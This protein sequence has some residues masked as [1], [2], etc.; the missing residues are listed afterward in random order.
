MPL[1]AG[2]LVTQRYR[3][4][5]L[6]GEG[7]FGA[8]YLAEDTRLG[9]KCV[10]LKES[11]DNSAEART[12]F[13]LEAQLLAKL[14]H[15]CLP[16]VTDNFI[17]TDGRQFLVMD[18][19][20]GDDLHERVIKAGRPLTEREAVTIMVQVCEA[21]AYLHTRKPQPVIHR[22]IKPPNI[23]ITRDG[24]AVLVD[25]GIAKVYNP[26]KGTAKVAKAFSPH[27]SPP[28]QYIGKTDTRSD[29]YALGATL[30]CLVCAILPP[31]AMERLTEGALVRS[32][33]KLNPSLSPALE[34]IILQ[35]L[36]LNPDKRFLNANH[37]AA[38]LRMLQAGTPQA[39]AGGNVTCP[40]CGWQNRSGSRF[41]AKDGTPLQPVKPAPGPSPAG[42]QAVLAAISPEMQFE[43]A[44]AFARN[45][46]WPQAIS[47]YH[48]CL[49]AG[50]RDSAVFHNLGICYRLAG[51]T[52]D[53]V[54]VLSKG[55]ASFP[56]D[57]DLYRQMAMA[58]LDLK[59]QSQALKYAVRACQLDPK[60]LVA[61]ILYGQLL[62]DEGKNGE[63]MQEF[64]R[65]VQVAPDFAP[66][67]YWL[68]RAL[69]NSGNLKEATRALERA[70]SLDKQS[71]EPYFWL[72]VFNVRAKKLAE[73]RTCFQKVL[74]REPDHAWAHYELGEISMLED[75]YAQA[76]PYLQKAL[77]ID[78]QV[79]QFHFGLGV[80]LA[81]LN[82]KSQAIVALQKA[83]TLDPQHQSARELLQKL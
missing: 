38:A 9:N 76:V 50:F 69:G 30:Y 78:G 39:I 40:R 18:F 21:V 77:A 26:R 59:Q 45:E 63:A 65:A 66:A 43:I 70:A 68:G 6:L 42:A 74:Q 13:Q 57:G 58:Y 1:R 49:D 75:R 12:Q 11:F 67:H 71:A 52:P 82:Q 54:A 61:A 48:A 14:E 20:E 72:G 36:D 24:R 25:F 62:L 23:K 35:A 44:N 10:A 8:V 37:F 28:E 7:G 33:S 32:P 81:L 29:V 73:A 3:I 2:T 46:D 47:A 64:K 80:C 34:Q 19:V 27:F 31:D 4:L 16:R 17:E 55:L 56:Q 79:A 60:D 22:D 51:R 41:C 83:L 15:T 53:A 5:R